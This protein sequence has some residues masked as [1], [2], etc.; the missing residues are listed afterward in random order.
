MDIK[1]F[2]PGCI[3]CQKL[4][5]LARVAVNE[6]GINA[7]IEKVADINQ[8]AMNGILSTPGLM[9]NGKIKHSGRPLPSLEKMK[10]MI[11]TEG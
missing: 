11:R 5:D 10:E 4:E 1:V 8:M 7:N 6:L 2:G 3:N 9:I